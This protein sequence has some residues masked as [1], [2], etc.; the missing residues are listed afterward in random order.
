MSDHLSTLRLYIIFQ[1]TI[2]ISPYTSPAN[3]CQVDIK[4]NHHVRL[5]PDRRLA[6]ERRPRLL[7]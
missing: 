5:H 1:Y 7:R 4:T 6:R 3:T 2:L